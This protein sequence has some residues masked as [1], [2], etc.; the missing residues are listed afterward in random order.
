MGKK[1]CA[2]HKI[3][4]FLYYFEIFY[5]YWQ[6]TIK[7]V[8]LDLY[9]LRCRSVATTMNQSAAK[10]FFKQSFSILERQLDTDSLATCYSSLVKSG[11]YHES[12]NYFQLRSLRHPIG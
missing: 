6:P 4:V 8:K 10:L 7:Y 5:R 1:T 3:T 11:Q 2:E 9:K 12:Q